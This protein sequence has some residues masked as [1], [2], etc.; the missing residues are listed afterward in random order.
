MIYT[1]LVSSICQLV[2]ISEVGCME[3]VPVISNDFRCSEKS[4]VLWNSIGIHKSISKTC[5][6][7]SPL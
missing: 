7:N 3:V 6:R 4:G 5:R 1:Y 2:A